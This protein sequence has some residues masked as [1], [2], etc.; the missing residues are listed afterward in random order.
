MTKVKPRMQSEA[1]RQIRKFAWIVAFASV[2]LAQAEAR[3]KPV[4]NSKSDYIA[5][6][7]AIAAC[8]KVKGIS[9]NAVMNEVEKARISSPYQISQYEMD[10]AKD[11]MSNSFKWTFIRYVESQD[12]KEACQKKYNDLTAA[13]DNAAVNK[14]SAHKEC[15]KAADYEGCIR[16]NTSGLSSSSVKKE[17]EKEYCEDSGWCLAKEG[18][19]RFNL[20][21]KAGWMYKE[22]DDG[23]ILYVNPV[24]KRIPHN[25]FSSRYLGQEQVFRYYSEPK[26][27]SLPT[28][29]TIGTAQTQCSSYDNYISC[30]TTPP[31]QIKIPGTKGSAGG[32]RSINRVLVVDCKDK[33][34][35]LYV[36][37]RVLGK[38][39]RVNLNG[40]IYRQCSSASEA[41]PLYMSL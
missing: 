4:L 13:Q 8:L 26:A 3:A 32:N 28:T 36:N 37:G 24:I 18:R 7:W 25:S 34:Q 35:A 23:D 1:I 29:T 39:E 2:A 21:K 41:P 33:T 5:Y 22:F 30:K 38:W 9:N 15:L 16:V 10:A 19:D 20:K 14:R 40:G 31:T 11:N 6:T 17:P 12:V 27:G